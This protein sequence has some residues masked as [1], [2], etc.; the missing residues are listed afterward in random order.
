MVFQHYLGQVKGDILNV[1]VRHLSMIYI[2]HHG[3]VGTPP[4]PEQMQLFAEKPAWHT[5]QPGIFAVLAALTE[6][7]MTAGADLVDIPGV[8]RIV[9]P[10]RELPG[11]D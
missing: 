4:L 7:A 11:A 2:F 5:G 9:F 6:L 3:Q 1:G 8:V 10:G